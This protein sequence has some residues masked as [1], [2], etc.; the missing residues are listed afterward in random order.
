MRPFPAAG[1]KWHI[2]TQGGTQPRWRSDGKELFFVAPDAKM[3][4]AAVIASDTTFEAA[5]PVALFQ[6]RVSVN[7]AKQEY[8]V[9][10][11]GRFLIN[12]PVEESTADP[13]RLILN[14]KPR[15]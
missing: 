9:S 13:I 15:P 1:A 3:M 5:P 6:T 10:R 2:S 7:P 11:D 4:A 14:W 8:A 12:E